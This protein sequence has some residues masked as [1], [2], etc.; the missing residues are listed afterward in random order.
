MRK[1]H[2]NISRLILA[3]FI[4]ALL[5]IMP[6]Y[7]ARPSAL[8]GIWEGGDINLKGMEFLSDGTGI[9]MFRSG[10]EAFTWKTEKERLYITSPRGSVYVYS[11]KLE[12]S[13]LTLT[14]GNEQLKFTNKNAR[15]REEKKARDELE[16]LRKDAEKATKAE[17]EKVAIALKARVT[18]GSFT[19]S[20]DGKSYK[21]VKLDNQTWMAE[22]L[23]YEA[24]NSKCYNNDPANCT[25]HGRLYDWSTANSACPSGWHLPSKA[26]WDVLIVAVYDSSKAEPILK[27]ASGQ[28]MRGNSQS[29]RENFSTVEHKKAEKPRKKQGA[30][31]KAVVR[32]RRPNSI[33]GIM[34]KAK[35]GWLTTD[36]NIDEF[37]GFCGNG[38]DAIGFS[39]SPGGF[40]S[41]DYG[42][43][44]LGVYW[45]SATEEKV[46]IWDDTIGA[47][48]M[49][50]TSYAISRG[51]GYK[52]TQLSGSEFKKTDFI[53][54]R[55]VQ[56]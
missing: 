17:A 43:F 10:G 31:G 6:C 2:T 12:G 40:Y 53:S 49:D 24:E 54:V 41:P 34:L 36:C 9:R 47:L 18:K 27:V 23:N 38:I 42:G 55:C 26:E 21:T 45:W 16:K 8:V 28:T 22:N 32:D 5:Q 44:S 37:M 25:K 35:S 15:E 19:D 3:V 1:T 29:P 33:A 52:N 46:G 11:Y 56:D 39:A 30:G 20:R 14:N 4:V 48:V 51:L 13:L 7:A 50:D